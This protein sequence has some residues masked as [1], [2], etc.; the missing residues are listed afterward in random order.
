MDIYTHSGSDIDPISMSATANDI[1]SRLVVVRSL[2]F[3]RNAPITRV[4]PKTIMAA[5][6]QKKTLAA[7]SSAV[8]SGS[9]GPGGAGPLPF[10][11][12]VWFQDVLLSA[13]SG[14]VETEK[15]RRCQTWSR[16]VDWWI[17]ESINLSIAVNYSAGEQLR[18]VYHSVNHNRWQCM[19]PN[20]D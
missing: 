2:L 3:T 4:L 11:L 15:D 16:S 5:R 8:I 20:E 13:I 7:I 14:Q 6:I 10:V 1:N 12:L 9:G 18:F 17:N 19:S